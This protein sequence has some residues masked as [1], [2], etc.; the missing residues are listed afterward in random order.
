LAQAGYFRADA[1]RAL[2]QEHA[3][4]AVDHNYRLWLLLN[5][6]LWY[7]L[8][9]V[10]ES[11]EALKVWLLRAQQGTVTVAKTEVRASA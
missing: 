11:K 6:E 7:R 5:M 10:G 3:S 1:M 8:F 4:G 9:V 2:L